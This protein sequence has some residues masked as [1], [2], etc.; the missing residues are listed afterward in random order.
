MDI[1]SDTCSIRCII[2]IPEYLYRISLSDSD[3]HHIGK[4]VVWDSARILTDESARMRANRIEISE[5]HHMPSG[6]SSIILEEILD[7]KL[8]CTIGVIRLENA[9]F[10]KWKWILVGIDSS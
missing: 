8:G 6:M 7:Y 5:I 9:L 1:V 3:L 4:E 2:V 10:R